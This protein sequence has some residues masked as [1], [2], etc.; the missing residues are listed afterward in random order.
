M[1]TFT[2]TAL[3]E[4]DLLQGVNGSSIGYG[5]TFVM[6]DGATVEMIVTDDDNRL[7]GDRYA[8]E[9]GDDYSGQTADININGE[10]VFDDAKIYAESYHVL[11][12]SDGYYYYMIE[13]ELAGSEDA[14]GE[15]DDFFTFWGWTPP[16]GVSLTVVGTYNVTCDW[17]DFGC[18]DGGEL[19]QIEPE[20]SAPIA[21]DDALETDEVSAIS[22]NLLDNDSDPDNDP[23]TVTAI[24]GG[25]I[26]NAF[27]VTTAKGNKGM[28][29]VQADG[30][31]TFD[32]VDGFK[33]LAQDEQD[34]FELTYTIS[35]DP[36]AS[37]KHN[38]M[39]V[40][41]ISNSTIGAGGGN[42]IFDGTGVGDVNN[43]GLSNTV[44][45]AEIAAVIAA[46]ND[47]VAQGVDPANIDIG[48]AT[49]SGVAAG[50]ANVDAETLGTF[51]LDDGNLMDTLMGIQS[52]GWT[53]YEAGLQQAESWFAGQAGD[54]AQNKLI[55][56]SDGRPISGYDYSAG[57][58]IT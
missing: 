19:I 14:P 55:F 58:Y 29:T 17:I 33:E 11:Q 54:G 49:F 10:Q 26:G 20:N 15:G 23:I 21:V 4:E 12:G 30:S 5:D 45:D 57:Q 46:V 24:E 53:N 51:A 38:L 36:Q 13:I 27:E 40:L 35:D 43:D 39:F 37:A 16:E 50:F 34:S 44:L 47:L 1:S 7:S 6:P 31:F 48:I 25:D 28:V 9:Y 41:D 18:L 42:N 22:A 3:L 56:L 32:P 2:F 8:N 52:G